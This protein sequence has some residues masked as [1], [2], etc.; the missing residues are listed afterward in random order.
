MKTLLLAAFGLYI[1][2][3]LKEPQIVQQQ[4]NQIPNQAQPINR[5]N[6]ILGHGDVYIGGGGGVSDINYGGGGG[7]DPSAWANAFADWVRNIPIGGGGGYDPRTAP[8]VIYVNDFYHEMQH[9]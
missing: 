9:H 6:P 3:Q 5:N 2:S 8:G 4:Q 7:F 1:L